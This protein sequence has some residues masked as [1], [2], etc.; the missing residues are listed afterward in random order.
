MLRVISDKTAFGI[1][2]GLTAAGFLFI[3]LA[4]LNEVF[5]FDAVTNAIAAERNEVVRWFHPNHLLYPAAGALW[6]RL[7]RLLGNEGLAIYSLARL[8]AIAAAAALGWLVWR[9]RTV[10]TARRS[11]IVAFLL[12]SCF[13]VWHFAVDGRA[14]GFSFS[15]AVLVAAFLLH[16]R[17][18]EAFSRR[19]VLTVSLL[20][21]LYVLAH[22]IAIFHVPAVTYWMAGGA[23]KTRPV[24][25]QAA[26]WYVACVSA[27][28]LVAYLGAYVV[29]SDAVG[30]GFFAWA[31]GYAGFRG[32]ADVTASPFWTTTWTEGLAGLWWGWAEAFFRAFRSSPVQPFHLVACAFGA[33]ALGA[34][35]AAAFR[36]RRSEAAHRRLSQSLFIW[37]ALATA[38]IAFWSPRQPGFRIHAIVPWLAA[39]VIVFSRSRPFFRGA[40]LFALVLFTV[41]LNFALYPAALLRNNIGYQ[42]LREA[43]ARLEPGDVLLG[44]AQGFIPQIGVLMPY[45]FGHL[46][47]GSA[48]GWLFA[49][50]ER[51]LEPIRRQLVEIDRSGHAVYLAGDWFD[52]AVRA[53]IESAYRLSEG[54][55]RRF[56]ESFSLEPAFALSNGLEVWRVSGTVGAASPTLGE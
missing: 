26:V 6:Y 35:A 48:E 55:T 8:N 51:S 29:V 23:P 16:H 32:V 33:V 5:S 53:R 20:S 41:N 44:A 17:S 34:V 18:S 30:Q 10:L 45:F 24:R 9:L 21:A 49:R 3:Y 39:V 43:D 13:A 4:T 31:L 19:D 47:G 42:A 52:P 37:G 38:F 46:R 56:I 7:E 25:R 2:A 22:G 36:I 54:E 40:L 14:V 12:G 50:Q 15:F 28:L 27:I 1:A 11:A